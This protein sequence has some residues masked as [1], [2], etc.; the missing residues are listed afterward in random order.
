MPPNLAKLSR[1]LQELAKFLWLDADLI[2][3][4]VRSSAK[5][6]VLQPGAKDRTAWIAALDIQEKDELLLPPCKATCHNWARSFINAFNAIGPAAIPYPI[7]QQRHVVVP[8]NCLPRLSSKAKKPKLKKN[9]RLPRRVKERDR[10]AAHA[11]FLNHF[12][13]TRRRSLWAS[14]SMRAG[15][16]ATRSINLSP[17]SSNF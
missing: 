10:A 3:V 5:A 17:P 14:Y 16:C 8:R 6:T 1:P 12:P 9:A 7:H 11:V 13:S 15:A 2:K 4:A